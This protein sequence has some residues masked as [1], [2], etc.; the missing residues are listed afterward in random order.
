MSNITQKSAKNII[1]L[2]DRI[3]ILI[4]SLFTM[5]S[6]KNTQ[7]QHDST[8]KH[9]EGTDQIKTRIGERLTD[10]T[11]YKEKAASGNIMES[12]NAFHVEAMQGFQTKYIYTEKSRENTR[13]SNSY[14]I[15]PSECYIYG[16]R[17]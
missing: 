7:E 3:H 13:Q 5:A 12:N 10:Q 11:A 14:N 2:H 15:K 1:L 6:Y 9:E 17:A 4:S 8:R 16:Y